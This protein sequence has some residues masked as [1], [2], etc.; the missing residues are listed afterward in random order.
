MLR[1][2]KIAFGWFAAACA[3]AALWT[4]AK[5]HFVA[6]TCWGFF[7][8]HYGYSAYVESAAVLLCWCSP[9][10]L[11]CLAAI[12]LS[13][14]RDAWLGLLAGVAYYGNRRQR[15]ACAILGALAVI[16]G[17]LLK[18]HAYN[19]SVR[20]HIWW[21]MLR[22]VAWYNPRGLDPHSYTIMWAGK[23]VEKAHSDLLQLL[24]DWGWLAWALTVIDLVLFLRWA[25]RGKPTP[26]KAALLCLATQ[27]VFDN[28]LHRPVCVLAL[29][30]VLSFVLAEQ[31]LQNAPAPEVGD[32]PGHDFTTSEIVQW[33]DSVRARAARLLLR[34]PPAG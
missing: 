33:L 15:L 34:A 32:S 5:Y 17:A 14:N 11:L 22:D 7:W 9:A 23:A 1:W 10:S 12:A 24:V 6:G 18:P 21:T 25:T 26:A 29:A 3:C 19:D 2:S 28:R 30:A 27:S 4:G 31:L 16:L 20:L 8:P 13:L